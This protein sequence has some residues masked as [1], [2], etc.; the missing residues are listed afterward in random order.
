MG[1][2]NIFPYYG[3][4]I[5]TYWI[6]KTHT[7]PRY[8]KLVSIDFPMNGNVSSQFMENR[9]EYPYLS[10]S[11]ILRNFSCECAILYE[12]YV[13]YMRELVSRTLVGSI[14]DRVNRSN[15]KPFN[16]FVRKDFMSIKSIKR[17]KSTN[18]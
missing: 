5:K 1:K 15:F 16:F 8:G 18:H 7:I 12:S 17:I 11:W 10:H 13:K 2:T 9:W 4:W 3:I 6:K 14:V